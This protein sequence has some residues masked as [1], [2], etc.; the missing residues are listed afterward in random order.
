MLPDRNAAGVPPTLSATRTVTSTPRGPRGRA[1]LCHERGD[2]RMP[3]VPLPE[4]RDVSTEALRDG[5]RRMPA[6]AVGAEATA[7]T[8]AICEG[9]AGFGGVRGAPPRLTTP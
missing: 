5:A 6:Q 7:R 3:I 4:G 8:G 2:R 9:M 1:V